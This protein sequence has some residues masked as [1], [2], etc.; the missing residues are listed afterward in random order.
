VSLVEVQRVLVRALR[1]P[2]PAAF[3]RAAVARDDCVLSADERAWLL[4]AGDDGLRLTRLLVRKLRLQ[5][6]LRGDRD[7]AAAMAADPAEFA[8]RF[9]AYDEEVEPRAVFPR[10]EAAAFRARG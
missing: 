8:R 7:A 4:A 10:D 9:A 2:D 6:L 1:D 3:V 5:R